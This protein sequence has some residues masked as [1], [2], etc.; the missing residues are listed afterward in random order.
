MDIDLTAPSEDLGIQLII[1]ETTDPEV[2]HK[3]ATDPTVLAIAARAVGLGPEQRRRISALHDTTFSLYRIPRTRLKHRVRHAG[4][5][6]HLTTRAINER[7]YDLLTCPDPGGFC[8][9]YHTCGTAGFPLAVQD[10]V[11]AHLA[12]DYLTSDEQR[13][14]TAPWDD[15]AG[16]TPTPVN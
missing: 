11:Y 16:P 8:S 9:P 2:R 14:F 12:S 5:P 15:V 10:A 7:L 3:V 6:D 13:L 1:E 4:G